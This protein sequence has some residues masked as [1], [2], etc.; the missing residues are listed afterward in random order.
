MKIENLLEKKFDMPISQ[1]KTSGI[2][3][4]KNIPHLGTGVQAI[5]Y[6]HK[7]FPGKVVKM[8]S[9]EGEND[10]SY[11]FLRL[12]VN[13]PENPYFP[14]IYAYKQ[15]NTSGEQESHDTYTERGQKYEEI[16]P[17]DSPPEWNT[18]QMLVVMERLY[19]LQSNEKM[20]IEM[21]QSI[22]ILPTDLTKLPPRMG[23][24]EVRPPL[25]GTQFPFL[26]S[27]SRKQL[28]NTTQDRNLKQALRLLE[29]LFNKFYPDLRKTNIMFRKG[30]NG[31]HLV[32]VDPIC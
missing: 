32:F 23:T 9:I 17:E 26:T 12:C 22:G 28:F 24:N 29:P 5:A 1:K 13:H 6:Y 14:K 8:V 27:E 16:D 10:P 11:Q 7:K 19:D 20:A 15:Y 21:L 2:L 18:H 31:T 4:N 30:Q 25:A 3:K